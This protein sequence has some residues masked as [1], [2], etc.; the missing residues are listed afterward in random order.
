MEE[1]NTPGPEQGSL[2]IRYD[3]SDILKLGAIAFAFSLLGCLC[4]IWLTRKK[5]N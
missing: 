5:S 2:L 1:Q 4:A 3:E